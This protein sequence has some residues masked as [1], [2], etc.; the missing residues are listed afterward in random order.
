MYKQIIR[1]IKD[2]LCDNKIN[3]MFSII[4]VLIFLLE[5]S[6]VNLPMEGSKEKRLAVYKEISDRKLY[7][8]DITEFVND[9]RRDKDLIE[10]ARYNG[11][12]VQVDYGENV[13]KNRYL[14][15]K[16]DPTS[17]TLIDEP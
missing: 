1:G 10:F 4:F 12:V 14:L 3:I 9:L 6:M 11:Y 8:I 5:L 2:F 15:V 16:T 13:N 7:S 17:I